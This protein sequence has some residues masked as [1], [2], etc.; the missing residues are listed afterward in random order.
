MKGDIRARQDK[1]LQVWLDN[2][3]LPLDTVAE[4][5]GVSIKT[6]YR[7][8]QDKEF[9]ERYHEEQKKR[10]ASLEGKAIALLEQ[11]MTDG[12]WQAIKYVLDGTDHKP[13]DKVS[14]NTTVI[15]VSIDEE[16]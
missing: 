7:Y 14:L 16:E 5:A 15:T 3:T 9:M 12:N 4:M 6:F 1:C 10:F 11:Q 13:E 2:P 8:R